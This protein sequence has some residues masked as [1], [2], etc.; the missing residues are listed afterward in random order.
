MGVEA[1]PRREGRMSALD[2]VGEMVNGIKSLATPL[3]DLILREAMTDREYA[4]KAAAELAA[5]KARVKQAEENWHKN[6]ARV[7]KLQES[8]KAA[9]IQLEATQRNWDED[10]LFRCNDILV[11][12]LK[13]AE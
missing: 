5:L 4:N 8:I 9:K 1:Q 11:D 7:A 10:C 2:E 6:E 12:A 13:G 3:Q